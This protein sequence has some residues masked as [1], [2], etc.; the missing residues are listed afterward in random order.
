MRRSTDDL[1]QQ[2]RTAKRQKLIHRYFVGNTNGS[3]G[4]ICWNYTIGIVLH[5]TKNVAETRHRLVRHI[6]ENYQIQA[7]S[8]TESTIWINY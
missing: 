1:I 5:C 4:D 7:I 3:D 8:Q 6:E 2:L